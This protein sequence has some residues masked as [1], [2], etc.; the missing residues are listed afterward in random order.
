MVVDVYAKWAGP[1]VVMKPVILKIK[2]KVSLA[3][4]QRAFNRAD[5]S[6]N[7]VMSMMTL[8]STAQPA[9]TSSLSWSHLKISVLLFS[10]S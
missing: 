8:S 4:S 9:L 7:L 1:C 10:S 3:E 5:Y 2:A 6:F